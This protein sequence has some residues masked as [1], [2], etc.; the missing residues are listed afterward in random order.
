MRSSL[1]HHR[2]TLESAALLNGCSNDKATHEGKNK[3]IQGVSPSIIDRQPHN[4]RWQSTRDDPGSRQEASCH[5]SIP[6]AVALQPQ[7]LIS[8]YATHRPLQ[9]QASHCSRV[10]GPIIIILSSHPIA[11]AAKSPSLASSEIGANLV[12][13]F[14]HETKASRSYDP[15][16]KTASSRSPSLEWPKNRFDRV[17][18]CWFWRY[19]YRLR[20]CRSGRR[21]SRSAVCL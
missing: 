17:L 13:A 7:V 8:P 21:K 18:C 3:V 16:S 19:R 14:A 11:S 9:P 15:T 1:A 20:D 10:T 4:N 2:I 5:E 6:I 12:P